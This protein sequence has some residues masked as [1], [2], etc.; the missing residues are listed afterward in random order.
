MAE[1]DD[2]VAVQVPDDGLIVKR[3]V[4]VIANPNDPDC[5]LLLLKSDNLAYPIQMAPEGSRIVGVKV[6]SM[7]E[8]SK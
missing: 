5:P 6:F 7:D 1:P 2:V 4:Q 3:L 8:G